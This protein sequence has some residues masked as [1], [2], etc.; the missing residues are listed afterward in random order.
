MI[1]VLFIRY[2][3]L[4][5]RISF[6]LQRWTCR[7]AIT[8]KHWCLIFRLPLPRLPLGP[9]P[10]GV[11]ALLR[12]RLLRSSGVVGLWVCSLWRWWAFRLLGLLLDLWGVVVAGRLLLWYRQR[13]SVFWGL[14]ELT[15][16]STLGRRRIC[17]AA[18]WR[19]RICRVGRIGLWFFCRRDLGGTWWCLLRCIL[20]VLCRGSWRFFELLCIWL[21]L[22]QVYLGDVSLDENHSVQDGGEVF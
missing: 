22:A 7:L 19:W 9:T 4:Y 21:C 12:R 11:R 15:L 3:S 16:L 14:W 6:W 10:L 1:A 5:Q 20:G 13:R 2:L 8:R 18:L 17:D